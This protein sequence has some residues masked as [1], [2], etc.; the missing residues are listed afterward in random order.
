MTQTAHKP[1]RY[2]EWLFCRWCGRVCRADAPE[3]FEHRGYT[4]GG[5]FGRIPMDGPR[6]P[7]CNHGNFGEAW[8][9]QDAVT[10]AEDLELRG[11]PPRPASRTPLD[12]RRQPDG[13]T[14]ADGRGEGRE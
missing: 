14:P 13:T 3:L 11:Y 2:P 6:C 9:R 8:T 7:M 5:Y 1:L 4:P 12:Q 10:E